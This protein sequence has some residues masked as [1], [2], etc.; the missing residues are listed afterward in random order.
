MPNPIPTSELEQLKALAGPGGWITDPAELGACLTEWRGLFT[1]SAPIMLV[2]D[3][4]EKVAEIIRYCAERQIGVVPQ[5][6]TPDSQVAQFPG[7]TGP[8]EKFCSVRNGLTRFIS[9]TWPI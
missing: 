5:G 9:S 1:G 4:T 3:T 8:V 2:P 6:A 7:S